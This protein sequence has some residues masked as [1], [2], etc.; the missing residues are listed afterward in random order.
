MTMQISNP[1]ISI[2]FNLSVKFYY[3]FLSL[4]SHM[5][6]MYILK[7]EALSLFSPTYQS[8][9]YFDTTVS[10]WKPTLSL[11]MKQLT[12]SSTFTLEEMSGI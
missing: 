7:Q 10:P 9:Q 12:F 1:F 2:F 11:R 5:V 8:I 3:I 4:K 6:L